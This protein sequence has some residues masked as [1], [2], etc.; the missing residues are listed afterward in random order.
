MNIGIIGAGSIGLLAGAYLGRDHDVHM[1][2]RRPSQLEVM[3][4]EGIHCSALDSPTSVNVHLVDE[5]IS[6]HDLLFVTVKQHQLPDVLKQLPTTCPVLFLQ[7]GMG[8]LDL[9]PVETHT[10]WVGVVEHGA[11]KTGEAAVEHLGKGKIQVAGLNK[12][13]EVM[14]WVHQLSSDD[15]PVLYHEDYEEILAAK[16]VV[17]TVINPLT[18]I[19]QVQNKQ[20]VQNSSI[21]NIAYVL[22]EEACR[23]LNRPVTSE[24]ERVQRVA[25]NTGENQSSMLKDILN[26]RRTEVDAISGYIIRRSQSPVPYHEFV[27]QAVHALEKE[28]GE[29]GYE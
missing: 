28:R 21:Q 17:N 18:A 13:E 29:K 9:L 23:V 24:W 1:Y 16:L 10:C 8:H 7:N 25:L 15:F 4:K 27:L 26:G 3:R 20:I 5:G 14:W 6:A 19:F 2:V 22:C 11:R 12:K